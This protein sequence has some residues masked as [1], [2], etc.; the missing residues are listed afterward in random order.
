ML[1]SVL[2]S[3]E[4]ARTRTGLDKILDLIIL[5]EPGSYALPKPF[6]KTNSQFGLELCS[7]TFTGQF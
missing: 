7:K 2:I 1:I 3:P 5:C 6:S 4:V